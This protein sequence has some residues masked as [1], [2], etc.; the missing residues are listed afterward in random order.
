[1]SDLDLPH[2][3]FLVL[4]AFLSLFF[5]KEPLEFHSFVSPNS[6]QFSETVEISKTGE[7]LHNVMVSVCSLI[8]NV[9]SCLFF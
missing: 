9:L 7:F 3:V 4:M 1:M 6:A 5:M 2:S 8:R